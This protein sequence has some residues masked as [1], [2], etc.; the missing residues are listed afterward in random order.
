M[1]TTKKV[2]DDHV[3]E[4]SA[5]KTASPTPIARAATTAPPRLPSPPRTTIVSRREMRS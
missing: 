2:N 5:A 3:G 1:R 4:T